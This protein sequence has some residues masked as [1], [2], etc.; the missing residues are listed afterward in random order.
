MILVSKNTLLRWIEGIS[1]EKK[2]V[3]NESR[4][5]LSDALT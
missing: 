1:V 4:V 3:K 2:K 5:K